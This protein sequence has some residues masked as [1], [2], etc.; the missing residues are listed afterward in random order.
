MP[1]LTAFAEL[2]PSTTGAG[3]QDEAREIEGAEDV[4]TGRP[5]AGPLHYSV[6]WPDNGPAR[7]L[8]FM[9]P[10]F[11]G[12]AEPTY[13]RKL[14][15]HA[16][17]K[18]GFA[19]VSVRYHC[20]QA[21]PESGAAIQIDSPEHMQLLGMAHAQGLAV[22]DWRNI[23]ALCQAFAGAPDRPMIAARL[24]I[25]GGDRQNFGL[26][27]ALDHL[28][29]LGD[30]IARGPAFDVRRIV[31]LG[32]SHGGYIAHMIAKIAPG[33]LATVIDN[34]SYVRPPTS[35][36]GGGGAAEYRTS[37]GG[38][39]L[40][41]RT[42]RAFTFDDRDDPDFYGRDQDLIRD[43]A[44]PPHLEAM[45]AAAPDGGTR[46]R[47]VN[48][49]IDPISEPAAKAAQAARMAAAGFDARL[50]LIG[51]ADLDG[52]LFKT[53]VHGLDASLIAFSDANLPECAPRGAEPDLMRGTAIDYPCVDQ[54]YRFR[55]MDRF[56]YVALERFERFPLPAVKAEA[57]A[58]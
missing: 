15:R 26:V 44:Y 17:L 42:P 47:M 38:V 2:D 28:R 40:E 50:K 19:A 13:A 29:V 36:G 48:A 25:P 21:R 20:L 23:E 30:L 34:S 43:M 1:L 24:E 45:R 5:R 3:M 53:L 32:S 31:A 56:P 18:H 16:C 41:C 49:A 7:G 37:F 46:F 27:Q 51:E 9:I 57:A 33:T 4:E 12:D 8:V 52:R 55:H 39:Q 35:Y 10:G 54:V 58:A 22:G 14:R 6:T 11:G